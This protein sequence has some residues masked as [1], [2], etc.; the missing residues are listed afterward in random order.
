MTDVRRWLPA[1]VLAL[2]LLAVSGLPARAAEDDPLPDVKARMKVEAER[3]QKE[4]REGRAAAYKL[5]RTGSPKLLEATEELHTL[6]ATVRASTSLSDKS[7]N[8]LIDTLK[9]DLRRVEQI[10]GERR[11]FERMEN[12]IPRA[13][14]SDARRRYEAGDEPARRRPTSAADEV[15][16]SRQQSVADSRLARKKTNDGYVGA[17]KSVDKSNVIVSGNIEFPADWVAKSRKRGEAQKITAKEKAIIKALDKVISVDFD[18]HELQDVLDYL[19]KATGVDIVVDKRAMDEASVTYK[20]PVTLKL[21]GTTR[22]ILKRLLSDLGLAYFV[23]SEAIQITSIERAKS[24]TTT[25]TYYIGD[26]AAVTD[27]RFGPI[28]NRA[29]MIQRVN[30]LINTITQTVEPKSWQVNNPDA[31]GTI[32]FYAPTM[33]LVIKQTAEMHFSLNGYR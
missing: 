20:T 25:R 10:A 26:L 22:T 33:T 12:T 17:M 23:K 28:V 3:V 14:K 13:V 2:S 6:L 16:K 11:R 15:I 27:V 29:L 30:E 1:L 5:V 31:V 21:K 24:E 32:T 19:R 18:G 7:R 9:T 8:E 4:V